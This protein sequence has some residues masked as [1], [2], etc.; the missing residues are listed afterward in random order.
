MKTDIIGTIRVPEKIRVS[1]SYES[2]KYFT[3]VEVQTCEVTVRNFQDRDA[4]YT[5]TGVIIADDSPEQIGKVTD[6]VCQPYVYNIIKNPNFTPNEN[7][8]K[9]WPH[10]KK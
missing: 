5:L 6:V 1:K 2:P 8:F 4:A 10:L 9:V 7:F 3:T